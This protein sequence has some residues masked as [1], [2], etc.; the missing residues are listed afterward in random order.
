MTEDNKLVHVQSQRRTV[1]SPGPPVDHAAAFVTWHSLG[2]A[3]IKD[4]AVELRRLADLIETD[5]VSGK[6][7][8][9]GVMVDG[10]PVLLVHLEIAPNR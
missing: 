7:V 9:E 8:E 2:N 10:R 5:T 6:L 3:D 1:R 4:V